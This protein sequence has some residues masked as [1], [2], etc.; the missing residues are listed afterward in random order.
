MGHIRLGDLPRTRRWEQVVELITHDGDAASVATAA[1]DAAESGFRKAAEDEGLGRATWLLTQIGCCRYSG[2]SSPSDVCTSWS[3]VAVGVYRWFQ[4][5]KTVICPETSLPAEIELD[6]ARAA[7]GAV[8]G[9]R[10]LRVVRCW[11]RNERH[12]CTDDC[13]VQIT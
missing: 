11:R 12:Y 6:A 13:V 7:I 4:G 5:S 9:Q 8:F 3:P 10:D 2:R 1:L